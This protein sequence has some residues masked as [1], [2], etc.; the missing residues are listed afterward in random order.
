MSLNETVAQIHKRIDQL[1]KPTIL[2]IKD[3]LDACE[4]IKH[5]P[6]L[7]PI[8][9]EHSKNKI[10]N[11][12]HVN[13]LDEIDHQLLFQ[14]AFGVLFRQRMD[15]KPLID[16]NQ[17]LLDANNCLKFEVNKLKQTSNT[18]N[19]HGKR[20]NVTELVNE[21]RNEQK[22]KLQKFCADHK[23]DEHSGTFNDLSTYTREFLL[24][25]H[26]KFE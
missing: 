12:D 21:L 14:M 9:N 15:M 16:D 8:L 17:K 24:A 6:E 11:W 2:S 13:L 4:V 5:S 7:R 19:T 25:V 18:R 23:I 26:R 3:L 1:Q 20:A 22:F 10:E